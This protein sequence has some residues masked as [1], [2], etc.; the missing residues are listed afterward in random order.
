M[1]NPRSVPVRTVLG[2]AVVGGLGAAAMPAQS[3]QQ[4]GELGAVTWLREELAAHAAA[5][6]SGR[7]LLVLFQEVPG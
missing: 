4:P 3:P 7:P 6:A 2:L 5:K 1:Q